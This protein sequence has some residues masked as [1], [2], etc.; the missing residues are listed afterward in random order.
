MQE[1]FPIGSIVLKEHLLEGEFIEDYYYCKISGTV[2]HPQ[3]L[4]KPAGTYAFIYHVG[5]YQTLPQSYQKLIG[6]IDAQEYRIL[7]NG[8]E[9]EMMNHLAVKDP[10]KFV[11]KISIKVGKKD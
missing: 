2:A 3:Y 8:Y 10:E 5:S 7:G 1:E 9:Q 4:K 6:F 11:L